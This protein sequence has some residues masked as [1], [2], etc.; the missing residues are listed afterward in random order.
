MKGINWVGIYTFIRREIERM[1]RIVV[2]SLVAPLI[3]ATLFIFIFGFV[4]GKRIDLIAGVPYMQFVFPG[5]LVMNIL[6]SAFDNSSS[7]MFFQRWIKSIHEMLVAPFAYLEMVIS[8]VL[9]A[10]M[11]GLVVG[12]GVLIIGL[13]FKAVHIANFPLFLLLAVAIAVIFSLLGIL[14]GLWAKGFE[15]L[16]LLNIFVVTP[17]SFLGGMFYSVEFLPETMKTITFLNPI[18]YMIDAMRYATLGIHES[19]LMVGT[20]III[21]LILGLGALVV[22]LFKIGWKLRE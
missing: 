20:I 15:Q 8:F 10:V 1:F 9:S 17:L 4:L 19:N 2:Q 13:L 14:V 22:H 6:A 12:T 16:G 21:G 3:S 7:A 11:R 5:I 18:F